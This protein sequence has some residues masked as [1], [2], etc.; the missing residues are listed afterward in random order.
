MYLC[1]YALVKAGFPQS[2]SISITITLLGL[3]SNIDYENI[4]KV[5]C[6][7]LRATCA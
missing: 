3:L 2:I 7:F 5:T 4:A 6:F 1:L